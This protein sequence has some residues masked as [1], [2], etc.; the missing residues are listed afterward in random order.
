MGFSLFKQGLWICEGSSTSPQVHLRL[1]CAC[2]LRSD[3]ADATPRSSGSRGQGQAPADGHSCRVG[4][5]IRRC[6]AR[7]GGTQVSV[8]C[9][10][11]ES[12]QVWQSILCSDDAQRQRRLADTHIHSPDHESR[13]FL[14]FHGKPPLLTAGQASLATS[15]QGLATGL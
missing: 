7:A 14:V 10:P 15:W 9:S 2:C 3:K 11:R 4:R 5:S 12:A 6:L 1:S 13:E 8:L